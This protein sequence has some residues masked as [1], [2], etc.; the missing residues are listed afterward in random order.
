MRHLG[1]LLIALVFGPS[2][3]LLTGTGLSAF[4]SALDDNKAANPLGALAAFGALLLA[5]A[6]YGILV[7]ARLSPLGPGLAGL[8]GFFLSGWAMFDIAGYKAAFS[9]LD[10]HMGDAVGQW[11]LGILLGVPLFATFFSSR[12][13]RRNDPPA[14][15]PA[16]VYSPSYR[17]PTYLAPVSQDRTWLLPD[18]P[19]PSLHYPPASS[20]EPPT[21]APVISA[22]PADSSPLPQRVPSPPPPEMKSTSDDDTQRIGVISDPPTVANVKPEQDGKA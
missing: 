5:G 9:R 13:W 10:V 2:V 18:T 7:M 6:L 14:P 3:F 15:P 16:P 17:S 22:P 4:A 21:V 8:A 20:D 11:G 12:R 19:A 1:S